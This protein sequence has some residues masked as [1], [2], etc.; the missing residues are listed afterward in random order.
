MMEGSEVEIDI[1]K[2][3]DEA[4]PKVSDDANNKASIYRVPF[5]I[6]RVKEDAYTPT[7]VSIGPFH[8]GQHP[9]LQNME[10]QKLIFV[11]SG[12]ILE[13]FRRYYHNDWPQDDTFPL[14]PWLSSSIRKDLILLEN[15][16]PFFILH[17]LFNRSSSSASANNNIHLFLELTFHY[18]TYYNKSNLNFHNITIKHFTDLIRTFHLHHPDPKMQPP[19]RDGKL[20][21]HFPS[22]TELVAAGLR[23]KG[24]TESH[25]LLDLNFSRG[26]LEIPQLKV[27]DRTEIL[28]RNMVALEQC[29]YPD[30]S[31]VTDYVV[32]LDFLINTGKD[33]DILVGKRVLLNWLGDSES[34]ANMFNGLCKNITQTKFNSHYFTICQHLDAFHRNPWRNLKSTLRRDYCKTPWQTAASTAAII[35]LMLTLVQTVCSI[36]QVTK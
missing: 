19:S 27:E 28:F 20:L 18:F 5:S 31:Y 22:A 35:L 25:C 29:L 14:T 10:R 16:L 3:L 32:V 1:E 21:T 8:H 11:D 12:F 9:R 23:F 4:N 24:N 13:L 30:Q 26:V 7:V 2:M 17:D 15:Q 6:R 36:L 33:V 34:V